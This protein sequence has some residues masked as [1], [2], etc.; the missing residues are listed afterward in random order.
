[1]TGRAIQCWAAALILCASLPCQAQ[2]FAFEIA[3]PRFK[4][5]IPGLPPIKMEVHPQNASQPH[6]RFLGAEGPYTVAIFTPAAAAGMT[7]LECAGAT[8]RA[9][10][11]RPGV[12]PASEIYKSRLND[13]T[14]IAIYAVQ[15]ATGVH[16]HAHLL[17]A[18]GGRNCIE[19]HATW[20]SVEEDELGAWVA[21]F[22]KASIEPE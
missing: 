4:V 2:G 16:L 9:L 5:S 13:K 7:P 20:I 15:I 10:A 21:A 22:E 11:A 14:F 3:S 12:P 6:L 19:V 18:G 17:S 1:M 8:V